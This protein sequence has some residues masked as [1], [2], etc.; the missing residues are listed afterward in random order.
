MRLNGNLVQRF[1]I[2]LLKN[3]H[4][5]SLVRHCPDLKSSDFQQKMV[6]QPN[7]SEKNN[8]LDHSTKQLASNMNIH[9]YEKT[10]VLRYIMII[11]YHE[12]NL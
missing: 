9:L 6:L 2:H 10:C 5:D 3:R 12:G 8:S 4:Q 7:L 11:K 1:E